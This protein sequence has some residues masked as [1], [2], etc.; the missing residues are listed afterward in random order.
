MACYACVVA[1]LDA[2]CEVDEAGPMLRRAVRREND[3]G[4]IHCASFSC[5][6]CRDAR[7]MAACPTGAIYRDRET[8]LVLVEP[9]RCVG[10]RSCLAACPFGIPAFTSENKMVKCDGCIQRIRRGR[11]PLC[12]QTCPSKAL[13]L[14]LPPA[15]GEAARP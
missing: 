2:H 6:H 3:R 15:Q 4:E 13:T 10:C 9:D 14:E 1:C 7:C 8:Q 11:L 5:M 12:V